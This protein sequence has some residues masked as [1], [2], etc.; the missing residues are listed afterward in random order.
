MKRPEVYLV[1]SFLLLSVMSFS[2]GERKRR[3]EGKKYRNTE[4]ERERERSKMERRK[5]IRME[6]NVS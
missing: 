3:R 2:T 1:G 4:R 6:G 5:E